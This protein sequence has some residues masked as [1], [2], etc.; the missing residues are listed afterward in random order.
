MATT[1]V[2]TN[3]VNIHKLPINNSVFTGISIINVDVENSFVTLNL[4]AITGPSSSI[5]I[6][7][8][9]L[10]P[11]NYSGKINNVI[12]LGSDVLNTMPFIGKQTI[13]IVLTASINE[14]II[15]NRFDYG[16]SNKID[17]KKFAI[18]FLIVFFILNIFI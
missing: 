9:G 10:K 2:S 1:P 6:I 17:Y 7:K 8:P 14:N 12:K 4:N 18:I 13:T 16:E 3:P 11:V 5:S 15:I